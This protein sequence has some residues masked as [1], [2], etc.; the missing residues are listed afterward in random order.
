MS[1]H[2][3]R[4]LVLAI[5]ER[6][7]SGGPGVPVKPGRTAPLPVATAPYILV[8]ARREQA[9]SVTSRGDEVRLQRRLLVRIDIVHADPEDD[10]G[11]ADA[12]CLQVETAMQ[13]DPS[14]GRLVHDL[15]GPE[16][17][18]D[19]WAEGETRIGRARLEYQLEYHT[20][21]QRPDQHLE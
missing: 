7:E 20:T 4:Q 10:D 18:L 6:L 16:T 11:A 3:R 1:L 2:V 14:F 8:H 12:L 5:V 13:A 17:T 21:A 15:E 9:A 19:A